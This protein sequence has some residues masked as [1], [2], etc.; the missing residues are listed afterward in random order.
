MKVLRQRQFD[1]PIEHPV[2]K[3]NNITM[4]SKKHSLSAKSNVL[5]RGVIFDPPIE[6]P[7]SKINNITMASKKHSLS[8]KSNVL[9][10]GVISLSEMCFLHSHMQQDDCS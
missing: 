2:S 1:P 7:V 3:I 5:H 9:H 4:A 6:H 8:A 10:R